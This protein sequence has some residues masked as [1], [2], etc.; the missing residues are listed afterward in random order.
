MLPSRSVSYQEAEEGERVILGPLSD[1]PTHEWKI[2]AAPQA[3]QPTPYFIRVSDKD[4]H[5]VV[6]TKPIFP[7]MLE[8]AP[9]DSEVHNAW[10]L[11]PV[12]TD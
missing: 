8:L 12:K 9:S 10:A 2:E 7:P 4:L 1:F 6:S 11:V 3:P 5:L